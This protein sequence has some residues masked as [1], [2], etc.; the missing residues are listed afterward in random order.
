[1]DQHPNIIN[2]IGAEEFIRN[3]VSDAV[4]RLQDLQDSDDYADET[5]KIDHVASLTVSRIG[6]MT[7]TFDL[8]TVTESTEPVV[9]DDFTISLA[10]QLPSSLAQGFGVFLPAG[11]DSNAKPFV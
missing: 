6:M 8:R 5:E 9:V 3:S 11:Q 4:S 7:Y 1:V 2:A 10:Q